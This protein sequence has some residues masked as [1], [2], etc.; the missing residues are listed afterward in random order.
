M[1]RISTIKINVRTVREVTS[2]QSGRAVFIVFEHKAK[3][4]RKS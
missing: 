1:M 4:P 2:N 3:T